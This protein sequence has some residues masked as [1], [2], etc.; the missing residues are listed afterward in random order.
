VP[1]F[2]QPASGATPTSGGRSQS[3]LTSQKSF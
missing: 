1:K 2:N 3:Y